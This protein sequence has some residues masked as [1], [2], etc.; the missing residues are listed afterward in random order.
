MKFAWTKIEGVLVGYFFKNRSKLTSQDMIGTA[1]TAFVWV[2][3]ANGA[4]FVIM[5]ARS[6]CP[7][8]PSLPMFLLIA[9]IL[10][11]ALVSV[12][13][14]GKTIIENLI[15]D[16]YGKLSKQVSEFEK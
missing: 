3:F 13:L 11:I 8:L 1:P 2:S 4:A 15:N 9:G 5:G 10:S 7:G 14:T 16:D 12:C 6:E